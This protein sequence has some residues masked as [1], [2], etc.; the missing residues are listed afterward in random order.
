MARQANRG[1][2]RLL[3]SFASSL[4]LDSITKKASKRLGKVLQDVDKKVYE[5]VT[6]RY[7]M[8]QNQV[9]ASLIRGRIASSPERSGKFLYKNG[10]IYKFKAI[11]LSR[12]LDGYYLGNLPSEKPK[13]H[14]GFVHTVKVLKKKSG[15]IVYGHLGFGGFIPRDK[16]GNVAYRHPRLGTVMLERETKY[17]RPLRRLLGPSVTGMVKTAWENDSALRSRVEKILTKS[18]SDL[19]PL[20]KS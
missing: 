14:K 18:I 11:D 20:S 5:A 13:S 1:D 6:K 7:N 19:T 17:K 4:E 16:E 9:T 12:F 2:Y 15:K 10:L 8:P 3:D